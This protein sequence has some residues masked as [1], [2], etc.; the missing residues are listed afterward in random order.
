MKSEGR[1]SE[2]DGM[3]HILPDGDTMYDA[4]LRKD[5]TFEGIFLFGVR[6]TGVFCRPTCTARKPKKENVVFFSTPQDALQQGYR[7]CRICRPLYEQGGIPDW[8]LPLFDEVCTAPGTSLKDAD[9]RQRGLDPNRVRRWFQRH[10][11]M[12]FQGYLRALRIG[13]AF[14]RIN[15]GEKVIDA[16]FAS[17]YESLSGFTES[18]RKITRFSPKQS[19]RGNLITVARML[20]PL[21]PMLAGSTEQGIC[22]LEFWDRRMLET[23]LK[24]LNTLLQARCVPGTNS[25]LKALSIQVK[26]YFAG[27]RTTFDLELVLHGTP[28]Q[29]AVWAALQSIPYGETRSYQEQAELLGN[30]LAV[31]A[32][33]KANGDNRISIIIPCHRVIGKNGQLVGYGG[34]LWRK[35]YL[36]DHE[37]RHRKT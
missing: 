17:G 16:A 11:G 29:K 35:S 30:P 12:T 21:G 4:L 23:Q 5:S 1:V 13:Q 36:L 31:R 25:R 37:S 15:H 8:L 24:R 34:G 2:V 33:A 28:F 22:L 18:F 3:T 7:P 6:T 20:T 26:E 10:H 9:I 27:T 32:V 19:H 14:G